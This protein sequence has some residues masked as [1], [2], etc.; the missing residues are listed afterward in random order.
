MSL[1]LEEIAKNVQTC[2]EKVAAALAKAGR[3]DGVTIVAAVKTQ[4]KELIEQVVRA[5]LIDNIGDNRV[6]EFMANYDPALK[7]NRHF[8]GRLQTNKVKY[9]IDKVCLIHSLDRDDLAYEIDRQARKHSLTADCLVE[10]N[11][12]SEISKGGVEPKEALSFAESV[13]K[14]PNVRVKGLMSVLPNTDDGEKLIAMYRD[15]HSLFLDMKERFDGIDILS[16]GMTNDYELA[17][18]YG[19]S[20]MIRPGRVLFGDRV[21]KTEQING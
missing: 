20:N 19:G 13:K 16:C 8:I 4:P 21:Y 17:V 18:T 6:Q 5:G 1:S 11:M 14:Y 3:N 15:L 7:V 12:G 9:I 10:V 2:R